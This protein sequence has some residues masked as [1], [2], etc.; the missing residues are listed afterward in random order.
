MRRFLCLGS[1]CIQCALRQHLRRRALIRSGSKSQRPRY[2]QT[3]ASAKKDLVD[4]IAHIS[5][6]VPA[7]FLCLIQHHGSVRRLLE[8]H[9]NLPDVNLLPASIQQIDSNTIAF[10]AKDVPPIGYIGL[11]GGQ[12][13]IE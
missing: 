12:G 5:A 9:G 4:I 1:G 3:L 7:P 13:A 6:R 10:L 8:L 11:S 2:E